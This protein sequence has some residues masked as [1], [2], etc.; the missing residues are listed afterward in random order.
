MPEANTTAAAAAA[1]AF[2]WGRHAA[3]RVIRSC[4]CSHELCSLCND[5]AAVLAAAL[6]LLCSTA[7]AFNGV[8][9]EQ[10]QTQW[11]LAAGASHFCL[12]AAGV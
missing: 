8:E 12:L 3:Q 9:V 10:H 4:C 11:Q 5:V 1:A 7:I 2:Y 6:K